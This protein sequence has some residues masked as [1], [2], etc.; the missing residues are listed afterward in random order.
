MPIPDRFVPQ[1]SR[2]SQFTHSR[3][4]NCRHAT[5]TTQFSQFRMKNEPST[6]PISRVE[7][8]Q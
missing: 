7:F 2:N 4:R 1:Y 3:A 5:V 8:L 6:G